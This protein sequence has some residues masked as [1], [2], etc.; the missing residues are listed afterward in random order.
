M[1]RLSLCCRLA[2]ELETDASLEGP[3]AEETQHA[4]NLEADSQQDLQDAMQTLQ[5]QVQAALTD[6]RSRSQL[7]DAGR[8]SVSRLQV[9]MRLMATCI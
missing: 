4:A 5:I 3:S 2:A 1:P 6:L 9:C 7:A 8:K